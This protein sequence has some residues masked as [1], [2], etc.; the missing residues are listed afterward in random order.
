MKSIFSSSYGGTLI[1][2]TA[3]VFSSDPH[4]VSLPMRKGDVLFL[5]KLTPHASEPNQTD[6]IRW[7]MDLRYQKTGT[8]TGRS[9]YP[10]FVARSRSNPSSE[11][12]EWSAW[13]TRWVEA[14]S[15][16]PTRTPRELKPEEPRIHLI[17]L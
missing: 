11:L 10:D 16:Y 7:S 9:C 8:P 17:E 14:L 15:R 4:P 12:R 2:A 6:A 5:H 1:A 13:K 3:S